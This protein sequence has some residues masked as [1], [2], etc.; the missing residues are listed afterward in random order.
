MSLVDR[1][2][3][4]HLLPVQQVQLWSLKMPWCDYD[5]PAAGKRVLTMEVNKYEQLIVPK[6]ICITL[7]WSS[8][9]IVRLDQVKVFVQ[10]AALKT[11]YF[12]E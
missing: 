6:R 1:C 9:V 8:F 10:C 7:N 5:P 3:S 4:D 11:V 12:Y 2:E